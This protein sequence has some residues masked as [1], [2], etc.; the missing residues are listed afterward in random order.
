M[1]Q[2]ILEKG[3]LGQGVQMDSVLKEQKNKKKEKQV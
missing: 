2:N 1:G 3:Q